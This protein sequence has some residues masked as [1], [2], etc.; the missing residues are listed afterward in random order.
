MFRWKTPTVILAAFIAGVA[1]TYN[2]GGGG[3]GGSTA[4]GA[5]SDE[6]FTA[7]QSSRADTARPSIRRRCYQQ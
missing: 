7:L 5:P 4:N 3:I 6:D 1:F 2:C